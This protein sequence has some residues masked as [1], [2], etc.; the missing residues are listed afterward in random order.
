MGR[1]TAAQGQ[2]E[3]VVHRA[4]DFGDQVRSMFLV[5]DPF[6]LAKTR[7]LHRAGLARKGLDEGHGIGHDGIIILFTQMQKTARNGAV[8]CVPGG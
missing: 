8:C 6:D 4:V 7:A 1:E 5:L 2:D 3:Q